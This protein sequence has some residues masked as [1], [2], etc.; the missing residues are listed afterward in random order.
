VASA[1]LVIDA[2]N[3]F[4]HEDADALL[5][6][7]R[8][9]VDGMEAALARARAEGTIV[10]YANDAA[11]CWDGD[12]PGHVARAVAGH[13]GDVV[14]R[15]APRP[16]DL[17]F[18]KRR[19]SAFDAT[20]VRQVLDDLE[21]THVFLAGAATEGCVVQSGIDARE[22]G[23]KV[24]ILPE[25]CATVDEDLERIALEYAERVGGMRLRSS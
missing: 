19:Y 25:A 4:E 3:T 18:F 11:G 15:I 6:S 12:A 20:P 9:R 1:L 21:V 14:E 2:I 24:T 10:V 23:L 13:G 5:A 17:F 16:G 22:L 7:F 8:A